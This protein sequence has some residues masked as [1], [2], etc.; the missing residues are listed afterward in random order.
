MKVVFRCACDIPAPNRLARTSEYPRGPRGLPS[1]YA[2]S[3]SSP[4]TFPSGSRPAPPPPSPFPDP[5]VVSYCTCSFPQTCTTLLARQRP[6]PFLPGVIMVPAFDRLLPMRTGHRRAGRGRH[7]DVQNA[8]RVELY[9]AAPVLKS[10]NPVCNRPL[11][12]S[13]RRGYHL[14]GRCRHRAF[15]DAV[16]VELSVAAPVLELN[17]V[18]NRST[19][20]VV[21]TQSMRLAGSVGSSD[22]KYCR[23]L[24]YIYTL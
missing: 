2:A 24:G 17:P 5:C 13:M 9:M 10:I 16:P 11:C 20:F 22:I 7:R 21:C 3:Q 12:A 18:R 8:V 23:S 19:A 4:T 15:T 14:G 1:R 6:F